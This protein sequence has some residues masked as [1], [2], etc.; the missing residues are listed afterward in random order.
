M[1]KKE[2]TIERKLTIYTIKHVIQFGS[3]FFWTLETSFLMRH[4]VHRLTIMVEK[5]ACDTNGH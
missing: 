4:S 2:K 3:E 5:V 1:E